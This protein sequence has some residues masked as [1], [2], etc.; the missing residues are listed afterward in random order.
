MAIF[1]RYFKKTMLIFAIISFL[2]AGIAFFQVMRGNFSGFDPE[3]YFFGL[4]FGAFIWGDLLIFGLFWGIACII[5]SKLN[6]H[7]YYFLTLYSFWLI[8]SIG[9]TM[10]WF[11]QQFSQIEN[12]WP[13]YYP[14]IAFLQTITPKEIWVFH[15]LI[16]QS[17]CIISLIGLI[18]TVLK[19]K[20]K[21]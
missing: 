16:W 19:L 20:S 12:P 9:E 21:V 18:Y 13:N 1:S 10:Y 2:F 15:Q 17:I 8:R 5:L 14:H 3:L 4:P 7:Y 11:T 6:N